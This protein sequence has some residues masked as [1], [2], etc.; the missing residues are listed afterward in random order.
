MKNIL[1]ITILL[2]ASIDAS[3]QK[4]LTYKEVQN[5]DLVYILNNLEKV[6]S[7]TN[8]DDLYI[9]V[10]RVSDQI[11]SAGLES[12]E[13]NERYYIAVSEGDIA[14]E[15]HLYRLGSVFSPKFVR[16][17]NSHDEPKLVFTY[18]ELKGKTTL[19]RTATVAITLQKIIVS[20]K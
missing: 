11:G 3:S 20:I 7:Y 10:Y 17:I 2:I 5:E 18:I 1:V 6:T 13:T 12:C 19:K 16:W 4:K 8:K 14:P 9:N 15:Q